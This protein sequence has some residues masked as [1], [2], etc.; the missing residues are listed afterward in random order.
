M[1]DFVLWMHFIKPNYVIAPFDLATAIILV[2]MTSHAGLLLDICFLSLGTNCARA[3]LRRFGG[4]ID[5]RTRTKMAGNL[6]SE[7]IVP[8]S[9]G[10]ISE[11]GIESSGN[12]VDGAVP[13]S[14]QSAHPLA[15]DQLYRAANL[16]GLS[17]VTTAD[18]QSIDG[19]IG[20][21]RALGAINFGMRIEKPGFNL[22]VI[23]PNGGRMQDAVKEVLAREAQTRP[24]PSD[25]VYVNNFVDQDKP[26]AI[27]LPA[28]RR[29]VQRAS[30]RRTAPDPPRSRAS[31]W[32]GL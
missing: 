5:F 7:S 4:A 20:Q 21:G 18:L 15:A 11:R 16:S 1:I 30:R 6:K 23:G 9:I 32:N 13:K 10:T 2:L 19:P 12:L 27:E 17:F 8:A 28:G 14:S 3:D 22:F 29:P 25:W 26:T 24:A 31:M